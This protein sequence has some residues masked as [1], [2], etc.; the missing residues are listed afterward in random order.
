[1][2]AECSPLGLGA[3][4][5]PPHQFL[6]LP[7]AVN[8]RIYSSGGISQSQRAGRGLVAGGTRVPGGKQEVTS[9]VE[10]AE[11]AAAGLMEV[12]WGLER[13]P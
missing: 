6:S 3:R 8:Q 1:M 5:Q 4:F 13:A 10:P 7:R 11:P 2:H 9:G 12:E